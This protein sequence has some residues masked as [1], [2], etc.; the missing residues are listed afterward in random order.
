[1]LIS[2]SSIA[3]D[4]SF[5]THYD[6]DQQ[7]RDWVSF[8]SLFGETNESLEEWGKEREERHQEWIWTKSKQ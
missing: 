8:T 6:V 2:I 5:P 3:S 1:M 7:E 4:P